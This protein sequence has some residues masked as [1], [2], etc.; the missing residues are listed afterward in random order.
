MLRTQLQQQALDNN[1]NHKRMLAGDDIIHNCSFA[2][3]D[4]ITL[5]AGAD[6]IHNCFS[7]CQTSSCCLRAPMSFRIAF[8]WGLISASSSSV[9]YHHH[10]HN[11]H[12]HHHHHRDHHHHHH[13]TVMLRIIL[14]AMAMTTIIIIFIMKKVKVRWLTITKEWLMR[15]LMINPFFAHSEFRGPASKLKACRSVL[16]LFG[17]RRSVQ[18]ERHQV[19]VEHHE[20]WWWWGE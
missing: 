12:D 20:D 8:S 19:P 9:H 16:F 18:E 17:G 7:W 14:R 5:L 4:F 11:N 15:W 10:H 1:A 3:S 2:R 6:L 13:M